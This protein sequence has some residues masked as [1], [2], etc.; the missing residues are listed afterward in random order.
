MIQTKAPV[1]I[2]LKNN[3]RFAMNRGENDFLYNRVPASF[4][5]ECGQSCEFL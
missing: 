4:S 1:E 5:G 3:G 2:L